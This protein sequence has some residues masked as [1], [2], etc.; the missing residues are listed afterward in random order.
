[1]KIRKD[2]EII[3]NIIEPESRVLDLG[4]GKGELLLYLKEKKRVSGFGVEI[5]LNEVIECLSKGLNVIHYDINLGLSFIDDNSF[6]YVVLSKTIQQLKSP[7]KLLEEVIRI[8]RRAIISFPNFG[9]IKIRS[10]LLC[11][12]QMPV[13]SELPY[14]WF[15]TPNIHLFTYRDFVNLCKIKKVRIEKIIPIVKLGSKT[16]VLR[17]L[18]NLLSDEVIVVVHK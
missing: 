5:D 17:F 15:D 16:M 12:G 9:N 11:R 14:S 13:T 2:L 3:S 6:D 8:S 18:P 10:Y 7:G 4:C 1:M